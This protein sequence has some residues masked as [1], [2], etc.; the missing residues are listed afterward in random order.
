M[1]APEVE[2]AFHRR[3]TT[4]RPRRRGAA[5]RR[6][7]QRRDGVG[8]RGARRRAAR[9][10]ARR[11]RRGHVRQGRDAG[12]RV[13]ARR[14]CA[15][16]HGPLPGG[17]PRTRGVAP[18]VRW[19]FGRGDPERLG[20]AEIGRVLKPPSST[21]QGRSVNERPDFPYLHSSRLAHL[22]PFASRRPSRP[23]R[24]QPLRCCLCGRRL[25]QTNTRATIVA[26]MVTPPRRATDDGTKKK[27]LICSVCIRPQRERGW[28]RRQSARSRSRDQ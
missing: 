12:A 5:R 27:L 15:P 22:R 2:K 28:R 6:P 7:R 25:L 13:P 26:P 8:R 17:A 1:T 16:L 10:G 23:A 14:L 18:H 20:D 4:A 3:C 24:R 21:A 11:R 9:R 19:R